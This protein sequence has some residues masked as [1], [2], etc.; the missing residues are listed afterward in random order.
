MASSTGIVN[1]A[2]RRLGVARL[3]SLDTDT[4]KNAVAARDLYD[5]L[6]RDLLKSHTWNFALTRAKLARLS[7]TPVFDY[8]YAYALPDDFLRLVSVHPATTDESTVEYRLETIEVSGSKRR[9]LMCFAEDVYVRHIFDLEDVN[10]MP[11]DFHNLLAFVLTR[12]LAGALNKSPISYIELTD[13]AYRRKLAAA[14]AADGV[15]DFPERRHQGSWV[16]ARRGGYNANTTWDG[17]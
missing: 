7:A 2:L 4:T 10:Q 1:V 14:K 8:Q 6:R 11:P 3:T 9:A 13:Q 12:D 17:R 16:H 15:E 5:Y